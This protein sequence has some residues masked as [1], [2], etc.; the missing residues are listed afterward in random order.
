M[1]SH[2]SISLSIRALQAS[3][4]E[5]NPP[6]EPAF[7]MEWHSLLP[8]P[9]STCCLPTAVGWLRRVLMSGTPRTAGRP[10]TLPRTAV[11]RRG[12]GPEA[13]A[14]FADIIIDIVI[15]LSKSDF[16]ND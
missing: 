2:A 3:T 4:R 12:T 1:A 11:F 9:I 13:M 15:G 14:G 6:S 8:A 5:Q 10:A 16:G 7:Y